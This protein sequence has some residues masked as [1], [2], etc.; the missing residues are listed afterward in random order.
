M[1]Y[2]KSILAGLAASTAALGVLYAVG[3]LFALEIKHKY[4]ASLSPGGTIFIQW[5]FHFL[6]ILFLALVIFAF[7]FYWEFRRASVRPSSR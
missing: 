2:M 4:L 6:P 5:H 7:G 3:L 1:A